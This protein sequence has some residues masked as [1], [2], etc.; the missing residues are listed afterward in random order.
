[1]RRPTLEELE[2]GAAALHLVPA[3]LAQ[4]LRASRPGV[5]RRPRRSAA[6]GLRRAAAPWPRRGASAARPRRGAAAAPCS[7]RLQQD[8]GQAGDALGPAE[9]A[10][11]LGP[12]RLD[13]DGR[14]RARAEPFGHGRGVRGQAGRSAT[15]VQ[16]ALAQPKPSAAAMRTTSVRRAMLSAPSQAGSRVGE[17]PA[18]VAQTD[19]AE[20]GVGQGVGHD[21]GV[22]VAGEPRRAR[23]RRRRRGPAAG[24]GRPRSGGCRSPGRCARSARPALASRRSA[25][26]RGRRASVILI[27]GFAGHD[28]H[29]TAQ[30]LDQHGVVGGVG[31]RRAWA[32][33]STSAR[34]AWGVCTATSVARSR[35]LVTRPVVVHA[36]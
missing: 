6:V 30:R 17:V 4:R 11:A 24:A 1:M 35:V 8:D 25:A 27:S 3:E 14:A 2:H 21:V 23:D 13:R 18:E 26:T 5:G 10:D 20:Q 19:R 36:P 33:R 12:G 16:S 29:R 9:R 34:K 31:A 22:A 32:R 15:T 28:A 7:R